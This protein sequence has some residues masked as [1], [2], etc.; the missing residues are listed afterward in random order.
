MGAPTIFALASGQ[1]QAGVAVIR[2]SGPVA[3]RAIEILTGRALPAPRQAVLRRLW[4]ADGEAIDQG[5]VLW[6]PGPQSFTGEDVAEFQVHGGRAVAAAMAEALGA[7]PGCR[8]AEPGE[9]AR[10]A[11]EN[12]RLDLAQAEALADLVA[13]ETESQ[14]RLALRGY[15][16]ALARQC[17]AWRGQ[18][19]ETLALAEASID[20]SDEELP[21]GLPEAARAEAVSLLRAIEEGLAAAEPTRQIAEGFSVAI[22]GAPNAGKSSL[23][24][25]LAGREAAIVS[26]LPGTTRDIIEVRLDLGGFLIVIADTAGLREAADA[27]ESEGVR[28]AAERA[29]AADLRIALFDAAT[30]P[31]LDAATSALLQ[32]GDI[33]AANKID[34]ASA[35]G[36]DAIGISATTGA[37]IAVLL[38]ALTARVRERLSGGDALPLAR[39]RQAAALREAAEALR[40]GL[41]ASAVEIFAEELRL[42]ARAL[43][44]V[45]GRVDVEDVLDSVFARFCLGK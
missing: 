44:R 39:E 35:G 41:K 10:R 9:F 4:K 8:P 2:V 6:F 15:G 28:R 43:G 37:G 18:L 7:V 31:A 21:A 24:N 36:G 5:L 30:A 13:A 42:A 29:R 34:L 23:L 22:I 45:A 17:E 32:P 20:F 3:R 26:A 11:F 40:R 1:G 16:G 38:D 12:G 19:I 25:A 14:R 27:I 33:V